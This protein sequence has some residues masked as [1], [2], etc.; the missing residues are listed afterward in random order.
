MVEFG[1]IGK[2]LGRF[3]NRC[4][5]YLRDGHASTPLSMTQRH[6]ERSRRVKNLT[7]I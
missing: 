7:N 2:L 1:F 4:R 3:R 6:S 5:V